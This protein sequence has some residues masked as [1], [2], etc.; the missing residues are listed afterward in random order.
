MVSRFQVTLLSANTIRFYTVDPCAG[1]GV[2]LHYM[3]EVVLR[4]ERMENGE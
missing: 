1:P 2:S 3:F 4:A